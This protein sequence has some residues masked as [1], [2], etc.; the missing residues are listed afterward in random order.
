MKLLIN[1]RLIIEGK[2]VEGYALSCDETIQKIALESAFDLSQYEVI[3]CHGHWISPGFIDIH[4]HGSGG[5]DVMDGSVSA[6]EVISKSVLQSG[7]TSFLATTMTLPLCQIESAL[8]SVRHYREGEMQYAQVLGAH[9]EGPF[10]NPLYKGAQNPDYIVAADLSWLRRFYDTIK[11]ITLAPEMEGAM[12]VIDSL[13]KESDIIISI[14]HSDASFKVCQ[15]AFGKGA[16]HVTH[17]FNAMRPLHHREPGVVGAALIHPCTCEVILD[18][19]HM[20]E[21]LF[22]LVYRLKGPEKLIA[23]TDSIR[24]GCLKP[25]LYDLGGQT[26]TVD[27]NSAR[28]SG[29]QLAGSIL[30]LNQALKNFVEVTGVDVPVALD[31]MTRNPARMLHL[32]D[33]GVLAVGKRADLTVISQAFEVNQTYVGGQLMYARELK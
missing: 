32:E 12:G 21:D 14:G 3:D 28:L 16:S 11:L 26:V 29:G 25:G 30:T 1:G 22:G 5:A 15:E 33:R 13:K 8:E 18:R 2:A 6:L 9:L 10:I 23:V 19:V 27:S 7:V 24:A 31:L 4:I 17:L 20:S